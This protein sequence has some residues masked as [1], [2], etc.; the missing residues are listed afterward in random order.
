M[1]MIKRGLPIG[2]LGVTAACLLG[3]G[4][5]QAKVESAAASDE[6]AAPSEGVQ[7]EQASLAML[8]VQEV[9]GEREHRVVWA[10]ARAEFRDDRVASVDTP[11]S[12]R[13]IEVSARVGDSV[14]AGAALAVL[15]S[16][17]AARIR[18]DY[19][20][21]LVGVQVARAE[22]RRQQT[23]FAGGV[24]TEVEKVA[25]EAALQAAQH[26]L[27]RAERTRKYLGDGEHDRFV[28]RA[29]RAGVVAARLATPGAT[30]EPGGDPMFIV[31]DPGA[32][33]MVAEVFES[34]LGGLEEGAVA[35]VELPAVAGTV[36]GHV[37]KVG[38][39]ANQTN[40]RVPVF[41]GLDEARRGIRPGMV[42]R[43]GIQVQSEG[44]TSIPISA[45]LIKGEQGSI[46]YV[47]RSQTHFD[48]RNVTLGRPAHGSVPVLNGL[49]PGERIVVRG[50]LLLDGAASQLM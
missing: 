36:Q 25:A 48:A 15:A 31:G 22:A 13:V 35:Q 30:V 28:L 5:G 33:W 19:S 29:P 7:I 47:Q 18:T 10:T 6:T 49:Q 42:G 14:V 46:V 23:M 8:D 38:I 43:A 32:L 40:G 3:C 39:L 34:D 27:D 17:E 21:A 44:I 9:S 41:I 11:V 12:A 4:A 45:V 16:P 37:Q 2:L 24:G 1:R 50:A 26:E 20:N